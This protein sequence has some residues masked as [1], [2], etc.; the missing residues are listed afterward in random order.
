MPPHTSGGTTTGRSITSVGHL[1]KMQKSYIY[2]KENGDKGKRKVCVG[3]GA[4]SMMQCFPL[5]KKTR[6]PI[7]HFYFP[8]LVFLNRE[9][10]VLD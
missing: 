8:F 7:L 4:I 6:K 2:N 9:V 1:M 5:K 10:H 3:G